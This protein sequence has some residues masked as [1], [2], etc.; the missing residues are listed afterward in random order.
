MSD[1]PTTLLEFEHIVQ[2]ND[3]LK[4]LSTPISRAQLWRGLVLRARCPQRFIEGMQ[5][6]SHPQEG[7][8]FVREISAGEANF[9]EDVTL[10]EE[11]AIHTTTHSDKPQIFAQSETTIEEPESGALFVRFSYRRE[12][13]DAHS[14]VDVAEHL[15]AAYR[16][17]D[18][19]AVGLIRL[20]AEDDSFDAPLN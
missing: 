6:F 7:D 18:T 17:L 20:M 9:Y 10:R 11:S 1:A 4:S 13:P 5:C 14:A 19:D 8:T 12:M 3:P 15:K 16:Q 2:V